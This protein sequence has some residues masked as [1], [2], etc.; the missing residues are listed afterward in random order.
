MFFYVELNK[1]VCVYLGEE[2]MGNTM[3]E[4]RELAFRTVGKSLTLMLILAACTPQS[5]EHIPAGTATEVGPWLHY[6]CSN[7]INQ[8]Q[9]QCKDMWGEP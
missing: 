6:Y 5:S 4:A 7:P 9:R 3:R 8:P 2:Y 1:W